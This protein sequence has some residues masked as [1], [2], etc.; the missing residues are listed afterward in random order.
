M[1]NDCSGVTQQH[2]LG[3]NPR[4]KQDSLFQLKEESVIADEPPKSENLIAFDKP[5]AELIAEGFVQMDEYARKT[6]RSNSHVPEID[7]WLLI[8]GVTSALESMRS[9]KKVHRDISPRTIHFSGSSLWALR[10]SAP[11]KPK[12][13]KRK[14]EKIFTTALWIDSEGA[15]P[16]DAD[17]YSLCVCVLHLVYPFEEGA[18]RKP[19]AWADV[20][21]RLTF[22]RDFYSE[23]LFT[24]LQDFLAPSPQRGLDYAIQ[25]LKVLRLSL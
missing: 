8:Q 23:Y 14:K 19:A 21:P 22:I 20:E 2:R 6:L 25:Y 18:L 15:T 5:S 24:F 17:M 12:K 11:F 13:R 4:Q 10:A 16:W 3:P 7:L 1:G 9:A